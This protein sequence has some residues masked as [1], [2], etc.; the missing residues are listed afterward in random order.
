VLVRWTSVESYDACLA[1]ASILLNGISRSLCLVNKVW[2]EDIKLISLHNLRRGVVMIIVS[3]I[4]FVPLVSSVNTI[5]IFGFSWSIF[6][7]PPIY[8]RVQVHLLTRA[9]YCITFLHCSHCFHGFQLKVVYRCSW[10]RCRSF[11]HSSLL[12]F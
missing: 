6:V 1:I 10:L 8:L 2:I 12:F 11:L 5:K 3:L 7:M 4:V 9:K